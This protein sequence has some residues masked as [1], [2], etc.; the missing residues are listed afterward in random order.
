M[1]AAASEKLTS[2]VPRAPGYLLIV[3]D[4]PESAKALRYAARRARAVRGTLT[5]L[6]II[7]PEE[8]LQW[9]NVQDMI[10]AEAQ[11]TAENL[12]ARVADDVINLAGIRPSLLI[13]K[14]KPA[15]EVAKAL[16]E[17]QGL[18][19]LVLGA[20]PKGA[21][22]PLV[23]HFSGE[24]AGGLSCVVIIVPGS[25]ADEAIDAMTGGE[26]DSGT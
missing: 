16:S 24:R 23:S 3:D 25:L 10:A 17:D 21:P 7:P 1:S 6:R 15:E 8:F 20:A 19:A 26:P 9:G 2:P 5:L 18:S 14:G 12:L 13:R 4:T 22:G 11:E